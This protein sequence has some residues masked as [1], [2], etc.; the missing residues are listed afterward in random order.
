VKVTIAHRDI[1]P[2]NQDPTLGA[3]RTELEALAVYVREGVTSL[4]HRWV[5]SCGQLGPWKLHVTQAK[6]GAIR[7]A[8]RIGRT[9]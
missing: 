3:H 1:K 7:H 2:A 9:R 4:T 8:N 6:Q 5:C